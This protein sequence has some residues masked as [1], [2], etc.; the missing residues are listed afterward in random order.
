[1][2]EEGERDAVK[3]A[4]AGA[5]VKHLPQFKCVHVEFVHLGLLGA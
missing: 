4:D 5:C 1:M 2:L 3:G